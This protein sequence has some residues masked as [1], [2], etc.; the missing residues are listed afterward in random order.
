MF[1]Y[2]KCK[3]CVKEKPFKVR[4]VTLLKAITIYSNLPIKNKKTFYETRKF[5]LLK[6]RFEKEKKKYKDGLDRIG[7]NMVNCSLRLK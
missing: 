6:K 4:V 2:R 3:G 5:I 7:I 1:Q